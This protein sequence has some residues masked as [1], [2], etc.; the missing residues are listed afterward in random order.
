MSVSSAR[1]T[2]ARLLLAGLLAGGA[3]TAGTVAAGPASAAAQ[4]FAAV[5]AGTLTVVSSTSYRSGSST[6]TILGEVRNDGK[7]V[8][9]YGRVFLQ[10]LDAAGAVLDTVDAFLDRQQ[11]GAGETTGFLTNDDVP[12]GYASYRVASLEQGEFSDAPNH[13]FEVAVTSASA[14][15]ISG[16]VKNLNTAPAGSPEVELLLRDSAGALYDIATAYGRGSGE[17]GAMLPGETVS[18][19]AT[20]FSSQPFKADGTVVGQ[21]ESSSDPSPF[22]TQLGLRVPKLVTAGTAGRVEI[23]VLGAGATSAAPAGIKVQLWGR[24][25]G[26]S[27][28]RLL[29]TVTTTGSSTVG[30][31]LK[32]QRDIRWQARVPQATNAEPSVS[33]YTLTQVA[34]GVSTT[35][36]TPGDTAVFRGG[37]RPASTGQL[38]YLQQQVGTGWRSVRSVKLSSSSTYSF[39]LKSPA[40]GSVYRVYKPAVT[41]NQAGVGPAYRLTR[42]FF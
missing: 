22:P 5:P 36:D 10:R 19:T 2:S 11:L 33:G 27:A 35:V 34:F 31:D 1:R 42:S 41:G 39:T 26:Q 8:V 21:A 16:T 32:P 6:L 18:F 3:L 23:K 25:A 37:V 30:F 13:R 20:R 15:G 29:R 4:A 28:F 7:A 24:E 9:P 40:N 12:A 14:S 38:V 17:N